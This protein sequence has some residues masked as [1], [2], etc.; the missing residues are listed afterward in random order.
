MHTQYYLPL[1]NKHDLRHA[2]NWVNKLELGLT[3][4]QRWKYSFPEKGPS[5]GLL[6]HKPVI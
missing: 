2:T 3:E 4:A 1:Q 5:P 6:C